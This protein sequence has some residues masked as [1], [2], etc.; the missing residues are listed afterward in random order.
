MSD[1]QI[2]VIEGDQAQVVLAPGE[3]PAIVASIPGP[4]GPA[5]AG[6]PTGGAANEVLYKVTS[7]F[8]DTAWGPIT[9]AMIGDLQIVNAD[10][11]ASAA[12]AG[13]KISPNFGSQNVVTTGTSTA[14]SFIPTSSTAPT[15]GVYL[16]AA[17]SVAISTGGSGKL[18]VDASGNVAIIQSP[19]AVPSYTKSFNVS[20]LNASI[21]L[22]ANSSGTY[23]DQG[24]FFAVD[25]V[26]YSQIYNSDI[27][28]LIFRTGSALTERLRITSTGQLS[29]IGAGTSGS[30]AVSFSG[31]ANSNSLVVDS[32]S[33]VGVG[34][35]FPEAILSVVPTTLNSTSIL[36]PQASSAV[37]GSYTAIL[38][39]YAVGNNFCQSEIRFG[40]ESAGSGT[41]FLQLAT[42]TNS[43]TP[44]LHITSAGLVGIGTTS[45]TAT[46]AVAGNALIAGTSQSTLTIGSGSFVGPHA[47]DVIGGGANID[48]G[49]RIAGAF[50]LYR[51]TGENGP[52]LRHT[53]AGPTGGSLVFGIGTGAA[54]EKARIDSSGRLLVGT[55]T[56][57]ANFTGGT[58]TSPFQVE[59]TSLNDSAL[60]I[61][62]N[63]NDTGQGV[64]Y[65]AKSR[66]TAVGDATP[67]IVADGDGLGSIFFQGA[68]NTNFV[69]SA[70]IT[71]QVDGTPGA[72]TMPGRLVFSTTSSTPGASPTERMRIS[73]SGM[74]S[75][76][77]TLAENSAYFDGKLR[78]VNSGTGAS[79]STT[80]AA[81]ALVQSQWHQ[82]TTGDNFFTAFGTEAA[83]TLRGSIDYNRAAGQVR[84]NV[85]SDRRLKS[86]IQPAASALSTLSAIQVRAYKWTETDY[87]VSHGFVAQELHESVP[88]AVKVGDD[89]EEV[90]NPWAVDNAKLVPLLTKALQ[91]ALA[92]IESLEAR[93]D[94]ANL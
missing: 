43:T 79:F 27:G 83:F 17:N 32:N 8:G 77:T 10:V 88:D 20:G 86:D 35:A 37:N 22:R 13:T 84:Y 44:R 89:Q 31:S 74:C 12:I 81:A 62:R 51:N 19:I 73:S 25:G 34:T 5:G 54:T 42:G 80:G 56:A 91:E 36:I 45:P 58:R 16:P 68:D 46:L 55:G 39:K 30:P 49:Y 69:N 76:N 50:C 28:Q 21:A 6:V 67:D 48:Y 57:R 66:S 82:A 92:K 65:L 61:L 33:R 2:N 38:S 53:L 90:T 75:I 72:N 59:G 3:N 70:S 4:Q 52:N 40:V 29:H 24:I 93:L 18:F 41:G 71:A 26:N 11:S 87:Q 15:N 64:I 23:S 14:A 85:T 1:A 94:A 9:S 63:S 78:V 60:S 7:T 47:V